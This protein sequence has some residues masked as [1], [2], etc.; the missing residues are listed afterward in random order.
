[1]LGLHLTPPPYREE[2]YLPW[3]AMIM[4][5]LVRQTSRMATTFGVRTG[6]TSIDGPMRWKSARGKTPWKAAALG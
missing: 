3:Q 1:M 6:Y 2:G 4:V 5:C